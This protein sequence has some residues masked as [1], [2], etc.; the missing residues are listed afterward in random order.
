MKEMPPK[1]FTP[2]VNSVEVGWKIIIYSSYP[3]VKQFCVFGRLNGDARI[4][5][6]VLLCMLERDPRVSGF[7][8]SSAQTM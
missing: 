3:C 1:S 7:S 6:S 5:Y 8:N 2:K 4:P